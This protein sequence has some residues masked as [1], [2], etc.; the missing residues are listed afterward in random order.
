MGGL[1]MKVIVCAA[2]LALASAA[3]AQQPSPQESCKGS[4][5]YVLCAKQYA[6]CSLS[7]AP[8]DHDYSYCINDVKFCSARYDAAMCTMVQ[9]ARAQEQIGYDT[10]FCIAVAASKV[11]V[12]ACI[13]MKRACTEQY[14]ARRSAAFVAD[15]AT[16]ATVNTNRTAA[17]EALSKCLAAGAGTYKTN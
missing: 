17:K 12:D 15:V 9:R 14:Y 7:E 11:D 1:P 2:V 3:Q 4:K 5:D 8:G 16:S 13:R 10:Q 6:W